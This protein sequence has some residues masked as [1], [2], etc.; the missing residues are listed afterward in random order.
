MSTQSVREFF[1]KAQSN[2]PLLKKLK[3]AKEV[4]AIIRIAKGEGYDF[5]AEDLNA[6]NPPSRS[7]KV[8]DAKLAPTTNY[9]CSLSD[10]GYTSYAAKCSG[11]I[12]QPQTE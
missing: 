4:E 10:C 2:E 9:G 11:S 6:V 5:S 8:P 1:T 12:P 7:E 3:E